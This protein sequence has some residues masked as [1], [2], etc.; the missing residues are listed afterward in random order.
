MKKQYTIRR[1]RPE[2]IQ[3]AIDWAATEGWNPG[4]YDA[5]IF[6]VV[7]A[8]GFFIGS[9]G[10]DPVAV[11]S[12]VAYNDHFAFC[13]LYIVHP[14]FRRRGYGLALTRA[15]LEYVGARNAGIDG[16]IENIPIYER[17]GYRLDHINTRYRGIASPV[18]E[19]HPCVTELSAVPMPLIERYDRQCFPAERAKFLYAWVTQLQSQ[20]YAYLDEGFLKGY[21]VRRKCIDGHK[22]GP[23]FAD[24]PQIAAH[25]LD[26][27][28]LEIPGDPF[29]LD[30]SHAN[31][32]VDALI[33][34]YQ[35]QEVF[36][37][38]RM[39]LKGKPYIA[40][41]KVFGVTTFELG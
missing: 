18:P 16:V 21:A 31:P 33:R 10:H 14:D 26:A 27:L 28:L 25:L 30:L 3:I 1:M 6:S 2:E 19:L 9:L 4:L 35:L 29:Y 5:E 17:V 11:G 39:Y 22:I 7:D 38:G 40:E 32:E 36:G 37:A 13:G 24:S 34:D 20:G 8:D 12:A 41:D 23:L 15:R